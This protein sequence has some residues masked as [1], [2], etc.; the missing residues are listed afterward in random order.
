MLRVGVVQELD[1]VAVHDSRGEAYSRRETK[2]GAR[3]DVIVYRLPG[4]VDGGIGPRHEALSVATGWSLSG[5]QTVSSPLVSRT[6]TMMFS[7]WLVTPH[8]IG[9]GLGG[10]FC[11]PL[12]IR[13]NRRGR[14]KFSGCIHRCFEIREPDPHLPRPL[15]RHVTRDGDRW[16]DHWGRI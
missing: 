14:I 3:G 6:C 1:G 4:P 16:K 15:K 2:E 5:H 8:P 12:A 13:R 11:P 7:R 9:A 10:R